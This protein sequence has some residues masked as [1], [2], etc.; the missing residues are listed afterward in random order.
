MSTE[1]KRLIGHLAVG[2]AFAVL[3]A[4]MAPKNLFIDAIIV[5]YFAI[6]ADSFLRQSEAVERELNFR[7]ASLIALVCLI[8]LPMASGVEATLRPSTVDGVLRAV[9]VRIG[10]DGFGLSRFCLGHAWAYWTAVIVYSCLPLAIA[11]AWITSRSMTFLRGA[12]Y[13]AFAA[14]LCYLA[15]PAVG[16]QYAF[17]NWP[18]SGATVLP[19]ID[20]THPRN[21]MPSMHFTWASLA[22]LN[23]RGR[24]RVVFGV[25]AAL[26]GLATVASGEHYFADVLAAVPFVAA[27]QFAVSRQRR[28]REELTLVPVVA[29]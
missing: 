12:L 18:A 26:M 7:V 15:V 10:L 21:C 11:L 5:G 29:R 24:W 23:A 17:S 4:L 3:G 9:D 25:Y 20:L 27:V 22:A 1:R 16:P 14:F 6:L 2:V 13:G 8:V 19:T 28:R